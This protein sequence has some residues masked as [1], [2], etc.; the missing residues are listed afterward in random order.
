MSIRGWIDWSF[1][2]GV[3]GCRGS[4]QGG[5][6]KTRLPQNPL[7]V[8][9]H[10]MQSLDSAVNHEWTLEWICSAWSSL[11]WDARVFIEFGS[12]L[13]QNKLCAL[14]VLRHPNG[15]VTCQC[16]VLCICLIMF[17][18]TLFF[19]GGY[20]SSQDILEHSLMWSFQCSVVSSSMMLRLYMHYCIT[21]LTVNHPDSLF[22]RFYI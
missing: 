4:S 18:H 8:G 16:G 3:W 17:S 11:Q 15:M 12:C 13:S 6:F 22:P 20:A 21:R 19:S 7:T 5:R 1:R 14:L 10:G 9:I 2:A